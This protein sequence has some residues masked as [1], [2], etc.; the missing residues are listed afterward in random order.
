MALDVLSRLQQGPQFPKLEHCSSLIQCLELLIVAAHET[1]VK[2][3]VEIASRLLRTFRDVIQ[4]TCNP[5]VDSVG[6]DVSYE[7]RKVRCEN[8]RNSFKQLRAIL[9]QVRCRAQA[10]DPLVV[11]LQ[12]QLEAL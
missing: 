5:A 1:Y 2:T 6:V 3:G 11:Q 8:A 7:E 9:H 12:Q 10:D 4:Q